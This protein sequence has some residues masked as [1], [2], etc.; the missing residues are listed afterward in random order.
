MR[1]RGLM[2]V[3]AGVL[4][5][6]SVGAGSASATTSVDAQLW[7]GWSA[8]TVAQAKARAAIPLAV[9]EALVRAKQGQ[10]TSGDL[11]ALRGY[12]DIASMVA[13]AVSTGSSSGPLAPV[14]SRAL[15]LAS[16]AGC[17]WFDGWIDAHDITG[18]SWLFQWHHRVDVC[19]SGTRVTRI[20]IDYHYVTHK[21]AIWGDKGTTIDHGSAGGAYYMSYAAGHMEACIL[22]WGCFNSHYPHVGI[23]AYGN[24]TAKFWQMGKD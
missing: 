5:A 21:S 1:G 12:T 15:A 14:G 18:R 17:R 23:T 3:V 8:P 16:G 9:K 19:Y 7:S 20:N 4:L 22:K 10:A 11:A 24:G 6:G 2:A 13:P